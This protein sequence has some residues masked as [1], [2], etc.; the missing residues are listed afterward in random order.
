MSYRQ[1][2][3]RG[4]GDVMTCL[5]PNIIWFI[6]LS[7]CIKKSLSNTPETLYDYGSTQHADTCSKIYILKYF[8]DSFLCVKA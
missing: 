2:V 4:T 6:S 1:I 7:P 5:N 3:N 8:V